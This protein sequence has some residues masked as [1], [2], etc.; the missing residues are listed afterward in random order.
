MLPVLTEALD[1]DECASSGSPYLEL[2]GSSH[3]CSSTGYLATINYTGKGYFSGKSH[4]FKA[5]VSPVSQPTSAFYTMEGEWSGVS[6]FKGKSPSGSSN[7]VFCDA[8]AQRREV[9][10]KPLEEQ[11]ERESRKL[12]C[13]VAQGIRSGDYETASREKTRIENDQRQKRKDEQASSKPHQLEH[14]VY[15]ADDKECELIWRT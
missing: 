3:I 8:S 7:S 11:S 6:K 1:T 9:E 15:I 12:W 13:K 5:T 4:C 2:T 10:V 14:F